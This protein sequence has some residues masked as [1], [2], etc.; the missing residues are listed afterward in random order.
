MSKII[1]TIFN[2]YYPPKSIN[3]LEKDIHPDISVN[4]DLM[5]KMTEVTKEIIISFK[6]LKQNMLAEI[7]FL[8][9][10]GVGLWTNYVLLIASFLMYVWLRG[11]GTNLDT[12]MK[13]RMGFVD[14]II[15]TL[16]DVTRVVE[17]ASKDPAFVQTMED[18]LKKMKQD[19]A[20]Q[21]V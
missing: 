1:D 20:D 9:L 5:K 11:R 19:V 4:P 3:V 2:R 16:N 13:Q 6:S 8:V 7:L 10:I 15:Y 17:E 21:K 14:G 18:D 12:A